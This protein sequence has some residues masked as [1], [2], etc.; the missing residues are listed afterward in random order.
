MHAQA[1]LPSN[2]AISTSRNRFP[3]PALS[4]SRPT[5]GAS[6]TPQMERQRR[7]PRAEWRD[8][9]FLLMI[10]SPFWGR[11]D[12][13]YLDQRQVDSVVVLT[14]SGFGTLSKDDA[15]DAVIR[16]LAQNRERAVVIDM[17]GVTRW[18]S[19]G[20]GELCRAYSTIMRS[21]GMFALANVPGQFRRWVESMKFL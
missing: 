2:S 7:I 4:R 19:A 16:S 6:Y 18:D 17:A 3:V 9:D 5:T 11:V 14:L 13:E 20:L 10:V 21:G 12:A 1:I 8:E 15:F